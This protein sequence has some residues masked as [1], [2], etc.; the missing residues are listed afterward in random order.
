MRLHGNADEVIGGLAS[1]ACLGGLALRLLVFLTR[2]AY[3]TPAKYPSK[4]DSHFK[5]DMSPISVCAFRS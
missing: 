1:V 2:A 4:R 3:Y 5:R